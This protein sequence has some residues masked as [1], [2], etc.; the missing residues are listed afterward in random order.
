LAKVAGVT[1]VSVAEGSKEISVTIDLTKTS[2][3]KVIAV[4]TKA[5]IATKKA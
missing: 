5:G 1:A 4:L 3:A 2:C